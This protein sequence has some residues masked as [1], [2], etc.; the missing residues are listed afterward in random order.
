MRPDRTDT[1]IKME[2]THA[3]RLQQYIDANLSLD[4]TRGKPETAQLDLSDDLDGILAGNYH[5]EAG[6]DVR[7]YGGLEGLPEARA[8]AAAFLG[9]R[10][11][12]VLIGGNSS[13][14][15]MADYMTHCHFFGLNEQAKPWSTLSKAKF[16]CPIPGY[17]RHFALCE[18]HG[19][20]M[21]N[22]SMTGQGPDMDAIESLIKSDPAIRGLWCVP[23]YANPT[24]EI[25]DEETVW[26]IARLGKIAS[27]DFR[28]FWD[29]A[30][31]FHDLD[32][33]QPLTNIM[34]AC[35][36]EGTEDSVI[37]FGSLSKI[38]FAGAGM[39]FMGMSTANLK[40][41][42]NILQSRTIGPDK[43]N[44]LRHLRFLPTIDALKLHMAKHAAI[45][46]PK[47]DLVEEKLQAGFDDHSFGRWTSPKGGYFVSFDTTEA[48]AEQ[49][50]A[51][52]QQAG[53]KLTPAGATYPYQ[54][55]PNNSNIRIAPSFASLND[56]ETALDVLITCVKLATVRRWL[57]R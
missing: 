10:A 40:A 6:I 44:Q 2:Q 26:R 27:H 37:L 47:F 13:L 19:I 29:N 18:A 38:T 53:V 30:Y 4:L 11:E 12:E 36:I 21:I 45:L 24:G 3:A 28:V 35:R 51:L 52:A 17:D 55:D 22:V 25:Y 7:N 14:N 31:A 42:L 39:A 1:L 9:L 43:V 20:E 50:I 5:S 23:K 46:K 49:V 54:R 48:V 15:L 34:D 57:N 32:A 33:Y 41:Y 56:L 16:I 8:F